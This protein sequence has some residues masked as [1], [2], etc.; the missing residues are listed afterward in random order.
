MTGSKKLTSPSLGY[1][2]PYRHNDI[3]PGK[4]FEIHLLNEN[5]MQLCDLIQATMVLM[6]EQYFSLSAWQEINSYF[7]KRHLENLELEAITNFQKVKD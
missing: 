4:A 2:V 1:D 6:P 7:E 5:D 3:I